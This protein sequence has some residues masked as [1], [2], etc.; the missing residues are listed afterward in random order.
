MQNAK[1]RYQGF[2]LTELMITFCVV[3][4]LGVMAWPAYKNFQRRTY[5]SEILGVIE[6]YKTGVIACFQDT[7][8]LE[9]CNGGVQHIP[10]NI[11][12]KKGA[13]ASV[14]VYLG[15]IIVTPVPYKGVLASDLYILTPSV[16]KSNLLTWIATGEAVEHG[17][18]E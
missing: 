7:H 15:K 17:Y 6:P 1:S 2:T 4:L 5:F 18:A 13:L 16:N 11:V 9:K 8:K 10:A 3:G 14:R 12:V